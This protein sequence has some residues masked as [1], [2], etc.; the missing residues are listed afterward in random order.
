MFKKKK[1]NLYRL[2]NLRVYNDSHTVRS[3]VDLSKIGSGLQEEN[4]AKLTQV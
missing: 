1:M 3:E 2:N 4:G